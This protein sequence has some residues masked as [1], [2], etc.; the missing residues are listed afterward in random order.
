MPSC[1]DG[2]V[3][4][5]VAE[6]SIGDIIDDSNQTTLRCH[7][8]SNSHGSISTVNWEVYTRQAAMD[9]YL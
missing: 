6:A 5:F 4:S 2:C 1:I 8:F 3:F 7:A 9:R